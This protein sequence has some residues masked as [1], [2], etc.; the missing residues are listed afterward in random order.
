MIKGKAGIERRG[1]EA[2]SLCWGPGW[3]QEVYRSFRAL[4]ALSDG[5][6]GAAAAGD[7]SASTHVSGTD[8]TTESLLSIQSCRRSR[9]VT[10]NRRLAR[11]EAI[12]R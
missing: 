8:A 3:E 12:A 2:Y 11:A 6:P 10:Q 5:P 1:Y 9:G 7:L 4:T